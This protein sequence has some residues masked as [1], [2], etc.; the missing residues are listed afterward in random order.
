ML[1]WLNEVQ[2][3]VFQ[4]PEGGGLRPVGTK[5]VFPWYGP[6]RSDVAGRLHFIEISPLMSIYNLSHLKCTVVG[7][8]MQ[9]PK[10]G[11]FQGAAILGLP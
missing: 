8:E 10:N 3:Q 11:V 4:G 6:D 7:K 2:L 1:R 5:I 9:Q